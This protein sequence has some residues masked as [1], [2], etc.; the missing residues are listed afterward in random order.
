MDD[1][2]ANKINH[3]A[4]QRYLVIALSIYLLFQSIFFHLE[5]FFLWG[6]LFALLLFFG[7]QHM[8]YKNAL[9]K[10]I[11][12]YCYIWI[13]LGSFY[14]ILISTIYWRD[15][16]VT[17]YLFRNLAMFYYAFFFFGGYQFGPDIMTFFSRYKIFI[18]G[19]LAFIIFFIWHDV[20]YNLNISIIFSLLW[21]AFQ[22]SYQK[23]WPFWLGL[24]GLLLFSIRGSTSGS[25]KVICLMLVGLPFLLSAMALWTR[26]P[27]NFFQKI[28]FRILL[29]CGVVAVFWFFYVMI[30]EVNA[31]AGARNTIEAYQFAGEF[32]FTDLS[33]I[34]RLAFW[35]HILDRFWHFPWGL[36]VGTPIYTTEF[37][38]TIN[39][40]GDLED[41]YVIGAHNFFI[42]ALARLG[43][44]FLPLL[45]LMVR[46]IFKLISFYL[47]KT[48]LSFFATAQSRLVYANIATFF[49]AVIQIT[50]N[51]VCESPLHAAF[52][53]FPFGL[54]VRF[55]GDFIATEN[56]DSVSVVSHS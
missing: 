30:D 7:S 14:S 5:R 13:F 55:C 15:E 16:V 44:L 12:S 8:T 49:A 28:I 18:F 46:D 39:L 37:I 52:F 19:F 4:W 31:L 2:L 41:Q 53:W 56:T 38:R 34:W 17:Y 51:C 27:P 20:R 36:G 1:L 10:N 33:G 35:A 21:I 50:F 29:I 25:A 23:S 45:F 22:R 43:V 26:Q 48:G 32:S 54:F 40:P 24:F 11:V 6:E 42:T 9:Q 3:P 47:Q